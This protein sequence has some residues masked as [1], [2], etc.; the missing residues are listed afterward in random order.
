MFATISWWNKVLI[1]RSC[2]SLASSTYQCC[3]SRSSITYMLNNMRSYYVII[4]TA[5]GT[6]TTTTTRPPCPSVDCA[7]TVCPYGFVRDSNGCQSQA[8]RCRQLCDVS[9]HS[10]HTVAYTDIFIRRGPIWSTWRQKH[11]RPFTI[12]SIKFRHCAPAF[13]AFSSI[14]CFE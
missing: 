5:A 9:L 7:G 4:V 8:C 2:S 12:S 3:F 1:I 6:T 13:Y 10:H 14:L 11:W